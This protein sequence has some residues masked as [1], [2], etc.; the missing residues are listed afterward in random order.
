[1]APVSPVPR[2]TFRT[3]AG[4]DVAG[5]AGQHQGGFRGGVGGLEDHGVAGRERG[6]DLPDGHQER[7]VPRRHL[8]HDTDGFAAH[9]GGVAFEV[10]AGG[11][12]FQ[13]AGG[14]GEEAELVGA[15]G[16]FL[17]GDQGADL[18]GVAVLGLDEFVAVGL[19]G[20]RE[21][22]QHQLAL[23]G[24][25]V[26]PGLEGILGGRHGGVDVGLDGDGRLRHHLA[27]GGIHDVQQSGAGGRDELTVDEVLQGLNHG[28]QPLS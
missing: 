8:G 7:V 11:L 15:G 9:V 23:P 1:M 16:N 26:L 12:A 18:P 3:P 5:Q 22:E 25:D 24:G 10:L 21:L 13:D 20:V 28:V 17:G 2:T 6:A 27:V 14:T 4:Q 19:D